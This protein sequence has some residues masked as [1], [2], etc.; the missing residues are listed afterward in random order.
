VIGLFYTLC[1]P[2]HWTAPD[3]S[4]TID[5]SGHETNNAYAQ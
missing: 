5:E 3:S 1:Y 4:T 2:E